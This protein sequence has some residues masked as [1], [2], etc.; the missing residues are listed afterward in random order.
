MQALYEYF[1]QEGA[2]MA[3]S[4]KKLSSSINDIYELYLFELKALALVREFAAEQIEVKRSKRL[5]SKEDLNPNMRFVEN[6]FLKWL[7]TSEVLSKELEVNHIKWGDER[8]YIKSVWRSFQQSEEYMEYMAASENSLKDDVKLVK[9]L[10]GIGFTNDERFHQ[11]YEERTLHWAD[12]LDAA[13]M[14]VVKTL[15]KFGA[16]TNSA[17][18][19]IPLLKSKDDMDF[20]LQLFRKTVLNSNKLEMR[21]EEKAKNWELERIAL[22]DTIL[23]KMG[24]TEMIEF[25]DIP[26]KVTLNEYID[27]SK[28]Y[29]S[30]KSGNFV[31]GILDKIRGEMQGDGEIRKIGRGLL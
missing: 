8:D 27:L 28:E 6:R 1:Q 18:P 11:F 13:Q 7:D 2:D 16:Q 12:D 15:R 22:M 21:I 23:L 31:N 29:S 5:P 24:I 10:Y 9:Q 25:K 14:L 26:I 4:E 19:L 20:A 3:K 30:P 17:S